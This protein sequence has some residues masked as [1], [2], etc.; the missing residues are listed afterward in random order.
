MTKKELKMYL[1]EKYGEVYKRYN[2]LII[3]R[4]I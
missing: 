4:G 3:K 2:A 1:L